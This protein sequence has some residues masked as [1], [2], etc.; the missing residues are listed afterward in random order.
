MA[1]K[2][3]RDGSDGDPGRR[4]A[5]VKAYVQLAHFLEN[6]D[7]QFMNQSELFLD[8]HYARRLMRIAHSEE[9]ILTFK[10][11]CGPY[12]DVLRKMTQ[13]ERL[14]IAEIAAFNCGATIER[15]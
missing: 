8:K 2:T 4:T 15:K 6:D 9:D 5:L 11:I 12:E 3:Q 14:C 1:L 7:A 13:A 10:R